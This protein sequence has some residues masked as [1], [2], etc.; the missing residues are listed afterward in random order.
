MSLIIIITPLII[1]LILRLYMNSHTDRENEEAMAEFW[2]RERE[3]KFARNVDIS[4]IPLYKPELD[5][6]PFLSDSDRESDKDRAEL[7]AKVIASAGEPM[8]DLHEY[9]NTDL[10]IKYG[11][12]NF[13]VLSKYDQNFMYFT[14]DVYQLGKYLYDNNYT[15][16]AK[17]VFE[18]LTSISTESGG[19]FTML[20]NIY[21]KAGEP[22]RISELIRIVES[23][24]DSVIK[25][26]TLRS[27]RQIINSY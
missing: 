23:T 15:D 25:E 24:K 3:A 26:T 17:T 22:E 18:Y 11:N 7:E 2:A 1:I 20:A 16:D 27:L 21:L 4:D 19:A 13:P 8:L 5:R 6:L 12:G 10:K 9:T 14:R